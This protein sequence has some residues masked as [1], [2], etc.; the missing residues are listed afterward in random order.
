MPT[1]EYQCNACGHPFTRTESVA[2]HERTR[3]ACPQCQSTNVERV[4]TAFFAKTT[5]KS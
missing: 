2:Q 1:Y 5:R 3:A 4:F